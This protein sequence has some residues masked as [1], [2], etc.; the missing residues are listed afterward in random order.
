MYDR[1]EIISRLDVKGE[2]EIMQDD[3]I[4]HLTDL[5]LGIKEAVED[6]N[7]DALIATLGPHAKININGR[8][9]THA[10]L[11]SSLKDLLSK[12]EQ[13]TVD[14]ISIE[15]S[16]IKE[17]SAF[18]AYATEFSWVDQEIWEEHTV[19]GLMSLQHSRREDNWVIEGFTFSQRPK[20][21]EPS[22]DGSDTA[23]TPGL[24]ASAF[25]LGNLFAQRGGIGDTFRFWY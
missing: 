17:D 11:A 12:I 18:A 9:L 1:S 10:E 2:C 25:G 22:L 6:K 13:P 4:T 14:I 21:A 20:R 5:V 7:E 3:T 16:D 8:F 24:N 19:S 15:E 23:P